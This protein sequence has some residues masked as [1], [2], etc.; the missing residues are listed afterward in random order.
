MRRVRLRSHPWLGIYL[1]TFAVFGAI[2]TEVVPIGLLPQVT[3]AFAIDEATAGILV[4]IYAALVAI[5]AV[6]LARV[7]AR[8]DRKPLLLVALAGFIVANVLSAIAPTFAFL[9]GARALAGISHAVF[10]AIALGFTARI[11]PRGHTARAVALVS[12][13]I[14]A[15]LIFGVPAGTALGELLGWQLTFGILAGILLVSWIAALILLPAVTHDVAASRVLVP[16]GAKM[17]L[18]C[19][20]SGIAFFGYYTLYSY[21]SP[22]LLESGLS[23]AWLGAV[24]AWLGI[25][26]LIGIRIAARTLDEHHYTW[27]RVTPLAIAATQIGVGLSFP[28]LLPIL[29][30]T[31]LWTLAWGPVNSI[32]HTAVVRAAADAPDM[33]GAWINVM[34]NIGIGGGAA[35]GGVL[36]TQ[37]GYQSAAFVGAGIL[38][39]SF[40][41][42]LAAKRWY[43]TTVR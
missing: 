34:S 41:I 28:H 22:M 6:P 37:A 30:L 20:L 12:S 3:E 35:L 16:G 5:T 18:A 36:V 26:G 17:L 1:L 9:V 39:S 7:T 14:A 40:I 21:V 2:T 10:F 8:F 43:S 25:A 32:Y 29:I 33:A 38:V 11:A 42:T 15:G 31:T 4:S 27:M 24:L 19:A 13:G 23:P